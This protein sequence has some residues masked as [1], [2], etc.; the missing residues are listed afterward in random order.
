M[1]QAKAVRSLGL[2]GICRGQ[3]QGSREPGNVQCLMIM[4]ADGFAGHVDM[5]DMTSR[6]GVMVAGVSKWIWDSLGSSD[7]TLLM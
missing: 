6:G 1:V 5:W 2:D 4:L 3:R 7:R